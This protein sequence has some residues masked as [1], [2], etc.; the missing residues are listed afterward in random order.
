[1]RWLA[2]L[3][4]Y[5]LATVAAGAQLR[6]VRLWAGPE[7]TRVVL[8]MDRAATHRLF[9]LEN[10]HRLVV[11]LGGVD[12]SGIRL[13]QSAQASGVVRNLRSA[14]Q[15]D[16]A[17]RVVMELS[18]PVRTETFTLSGAAGPGHRL[19]LD[20]Y[21]RT[22]TLAELRQGSSTMPSAT[23]HSAPASSPPPLTVS[24]QRAPATASTPLPSAMEPRE[25]T[26]AVVDSRA[27]APQVHSVAMAAPSRPG[28]RVRLSDK[29]IIVA[30][31]AGHGGQDPGAI[32][33]SGLREK[34]VALA[35]SRRLAK[36]IDQQ[37]GMK[38]V[39]TRDADVF[40]PLRERTQRA[41]RSQADLFVSIHANAYKDRSLT[42]S[43]VYVLSSN[44]ASSEHARWLARKENEADMVGGIELQDKDNDLA[45]VL[46]DLSQDSTMQASMDLAKRMLGSLAK[47]NRLQRTAVQEAGFMVLKSPDI[48]SVL[49]ET[50]FI[51]N[52]AEEKLL[53]DPAHQDRVARSLLTGILGYF[54]NYRPQQ[55]E[56]QT[57]DAAG[58]RVA[59]GAMVAPE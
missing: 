31:D 16:G 48:P 34:D 36:L 46:L 7:S 30:I 2:A 49:V 44:G 21:G 40:I 24:T 58:G 27:E 59:V 19:V 10:P 9:T 4:L 26:P 17:L 45:T 28:G 37:P 38:A 25:P 1:M 50:A 55:P 18:E 39:L 47:V 53:R 12:S 33:L 15:P 5:S 14:V 43:A 57:A 6:E 11:D 13:V 41:R 8:D 3:L 23:D 56:L 22:P 52:Q 54:D 32:G 29:R 20:L 51:S 35:I 42:G